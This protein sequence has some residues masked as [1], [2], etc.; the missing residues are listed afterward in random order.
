LGRQEAT[1]TLEPEDLPA[2]V[3]QTLREMEEVYYGMH[4]LRPH[5]LVR[6]NGVFYFENMD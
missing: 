5:F 4:F 1:L 3:T 2:L 6:E